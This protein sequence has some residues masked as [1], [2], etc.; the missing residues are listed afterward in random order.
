MDFTNQSGSRD[1]ERAA[2]GY[3]IGSIGSEEVTVKKIDKLKDCSPNQKFY[4]VFAG[5]IKVKRIHS[6]TI[7]KKTRYIN[8]RLVES[9]SGGTS[10]ATGQTIAIFNAKEHEDDMTLEL[11]FPTTTLKLKKLDAETEEELNN[12]IMVLERE[13]K[14]YVVADEENFYTKCIDEIGTPRA[15]ATRFKSGDEIK[16]LPAGTY[17]VHEIQRE[18]KKYKECSVNKPLTIGEFTVASMKRKTVNIK[19]KKVNDI[20]LKIWKRDGKT[21]AALNNVR[22][23]VKV[24]SQYAVGGLE[25]ETFAEWTS[26]INKATWYKT[27]DTI[28][29]NKEGTYEFLEV[30][31]ENTNY[32][33]CSLEAPIRL[34][35]M[36]LASGDNKT[37]NLNNNPATKVAKRDFDT[38]KPLTNVQFVVQYQDGSY[39]Q[40]AGAKANYTW[41]KNAATRYKAGDQISGIWKEGTYTC[42]EVQRESESYEY[43]DINNPIFI[44]NRYVPVPQR[45]ITR[46]QDVYGW[47]DD[48]GWVK[49]E[50]GSEKLEVVGG[51]LG[52]VDTIYVF[53]HW[54][55]I[56][57]TLGFDATNKRKYIKISGHVWEDIL[58][59]GKDSS[60]DD[61]YDP[62]QDQ[63]V[64]NIE[65]VLK[66]SG[67]SIIANRLGQTVAITGSDGRY[68][69]TEI[70]IEKLP[71][72]YVEFTYNGLSY[73][74]VKVH[75]ELDNGSK[76]TDEKNRGEFNSRFE[77]ITNNKAKG[78]AGEKTL[79]YNKEGHISTLT[80]GAN[81]VYGYYGQRYPVAKTDKHF[82]I[83]ANTKDA[84]GAFLG[85]QAV[86][87]DDIYT[88]GIDEIDN[89]NLGI[90]VREQPDIGI[91]KDI[92]NVKV[93]INGKMQVYEYKQR[94]IHFQQQEDSSIEDAMFETS[95]RYGV[96]YEGISSYTRPIYKSDYEIS[97]I[98]KPL[99]VYV[100]YKI[101]MNI[102]QGNL[103]AKVNEIVDYYDARY[104][105]ES[106]GDRLSGYDPSGS[107]Q[108]VSDGGSG[109]YKKIKI[110]TSGLGEINGQKEGENGIIYVQFKLKRDVVQQIVE[111]GDALSNIVEVSSYSIFDKDGIY[112]GIDK[113]SNPGNAE[114]GKYQEYENDTDSSPA[115]TLEGKGTRSISGTIF[116]D[117]TGKT[118]LEIREGEERIGNGIYDV[119]EDGVE[120]V[121]VTLIEENTGKTWSGG[122]TG[123]NGNF[124]ISG[125][126]P[127]D[128]VIQYTWGSGKYTVERPLTK[129]IDGKEV[130]TVQDYKG[131]IYRT[132]AH[133]GE[134]WKDEGTRL[135]DALDD[136]DQRQKIDAEISSMNKAYQKDNVTIH[137]MVSTTAG[138]SLNVEY[139]FAT[140]LEASAGKQYPYAVKNIDFGIVER[141]KQ[142]M[143]ISKRISRIKITLANGQVIVDAIVKEN[144]TLEGQ[145]KGLTYGPASDNSIGFIKAELDNELIQGATLDLEYKITVANTGEK[146]YD[147]KDYYLYG[148]CAK[149]DELIGM[150]VDVYDYLD[151]E[152]NNKPSTENPGEWKEVSKSEYKITY[153]L[154][155]SEKESNTILESYFYSG[156]TTEG[157]RTTYTWGKGEDE[158]TT[159]LLEGWID[160]VTHKEARTVKIEG[161]T[162]LE[163]A[164]GLNELTKVIK[165]TEH[166]E[167]VLC[168]S[169]ILSN[170]EEIDI[171]NNSEIT[172]VR[173][174]T[175]QRTG[176]IPKVTTSHF[177]DSGET[178]TITPP[179]GL[180][181]DKIMLIII[182]ITAIVILGVGVIIIKK[183]VLK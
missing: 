107:L 6:I 104:E 162:I 130:Y 69:F 20:K 72:A 80:Y 14:G 147:C 39:L 124:G 109:K 166:K 52:Y 88:K 30:Q 172:E 178:T 161:K 146:D 90:V 8:A 182:G 58:S 41:N 153:E 5:T 128:Y 148:T 82:E 160:E 4:L 49:Q 34:P 99:E 152:I 48:Y 17:I 142:R 139:D 181:K 114:P 120:G 63:D 55:P 33:D 108:H 42:W 86:S 78:S 140:S 77:V 144:G 79:S 180:E 66:D 60:Y 183:K 134:W 177:F 157:D 91:V 98:D 176:T 28:N 174:N 47:I 87:F 54:E 13:G 168:A 44:T 165:P 95:I 137:E 83:K 50:D 118:S 85:Q 135:S 158:I 131:T 113:N 123:A 143:E 115:L 76:A 43:A 16:D 106:V 111:T 125:Y 40:A 29:S 1:E 31:R 105:V 59:T 11:P 74:A 68:E 110:D 156:K 51:H 101:K 155:D 133:G 129:E 171:N 154:N 12:V 96:E 93:S 26:D 103:R 2:I 18:N 121:N 15:G 64:A 65:V 97:D 23:I 100:T 175:E 3:H 67:G 35:S 151:K 169:K 149:E 61:I 45:E 112:A 73:K 81:S 22:I 170:V 132:N 7:Q 9:E 56:P 70:E 75:T 102:A 53:D 179:T 116:E 84:S 27:G 163:A 136:Y 71:G 94:F 138:M 25:N 37:A 46:P 89:I 159:Q 32:A 145:Y 122:T 19:N 173:R 126:I 127:G 62:E 92:E 119:N 167:S 10:I 150:Q 38:K 117:S 21:G 36:R 164:S 24:G 141:P 57:Q